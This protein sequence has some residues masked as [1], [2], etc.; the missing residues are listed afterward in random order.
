[1]ANGFLTSSPGSRHGDTSRS[2][3]PDNYCEAFKF[4]CPGTGIKEITEIGMWLSAD[5]GQTT[6]FRFAIF[7]HDPVNNC[8]EAMVANSETGEVTHNTTTV[9]KKYY[10]Y[11]AKPLLTGGNDYWIAVMTADSYANAD[12]LAAG[13]ATN[14]YNAV[15][16]PNWI[17][18]AGWH[19]AASS[20][21]DIGIYAVYQAASAAFP[22]VV[23]YNTR[24]GT[25]L[26]GGVSLNMP[27]GIEAGDLL[28]TFCTNDNPSSTFM[29]ISGWTQ[30]FQ[31]NNGPALKHAC[32]AKIATG[33]DTATLTGAAQD[34]TAIVLRITGHGVTDIANDIKKNSTAYNT[35][36]QPNPASLNAGSSKQ[37]LW[38]ASYGA[39]DDDIGNA[40]PYPANYT[41]V[42]EVESA[43]STSSC[44]SAAAFRQ[45]EAQTEDPGTFNLTSSSTAEEWDAAIIAIPPASG[46]YSLVCGP[47]SLALVGQGMTP[48]RVLSIL[49]A[50]GSIELAGQAVGLKRGYKA[51]AAQGAFALSGQ[52]AWLSVGRKLPADCGAFAFSGQSIRLDRA[53]LAAL[54]Q[55]DFVL[56]GQPV[57]LTRGFNIAAD[58]G[59]FALMGQTAGFLRNIKTITDRGDFVL[60]GYS[61]GLLA[62]RKLFAERGSFAFS[63]QE[64]GVLRGL[65]TSAEGGS[66][67]QSGIA[68]A[69]LADRTIQAG[70]GMFALSGQDATLLYVPAGAFSF[71]CDPAAFSLAGREAEFL[72]ALK[73]TAGAGSFTLTGVG[74]LLLAGKR[75]SSDTGSFALA[76]QDAGVVYTPAGNILLV[77]DQGTFAL[78]GQQ[79]ALLANRIVATGG[80]SFTVSGVTVI[81]SCSGMVPVAIIKTIELPVM[82]Q[83]YEQTAIRTIYELPRMRKTYE[84][85]E[86]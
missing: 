27:G 32:F 41:G 12:Y 59:S 66:F 6:T 60:S 8:P 45:L 1:M 74:V 65:K 67:L 10:T 84:L 58:Q 53:L 39:D 50:Q 40:T 52:G 69:L 75:L 36:W 56:T 38:I 47:G 34:Y 7:T 22:S 25:S 29:G 24:V 43:S 4:T 72:R 21:D 17:F 42:T 62:G 9:T 71:P 64:A 83:V 79:A 20:T 57:T 19:G 70:N 73:V 2:W 81:F 5:S 31:T 63:G 78:S 14:K 61:A 51:D 3:S 30:V 28:L 16:Y 15:T 11:S 77:C 37:W 80:G 26:S 18:G 68:A 49:V 46:A 54:G 82:R 85:A 35:T 48:K 76:G 55:D 44:S 86:E 23:S 13:S 33:G